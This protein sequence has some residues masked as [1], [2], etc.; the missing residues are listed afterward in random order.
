MLKRPSDVQAVQDTKQVK[1]LGNIRLVAEVVVAGLVG[2]EIT[3]VVEAFDLGLRSGD[4]RRRNNM[5]VA[6]HLAAQKGL[7]AQVTDIYHRRTPITA[8]GRQARKKLQDSAVGSSP[9]LLDLDHRGQLS[10]LIRR[11]ETVAV[12]EVQTNCH[13][14]D[15][16]SDNALIFNVCGQLVGTR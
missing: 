6:S 1:R 2:G 3:T 12:L 7:S 8:F 10:R 15:G 16:I 5:V 13:Y 9:W 4:Q 11:N 14:L